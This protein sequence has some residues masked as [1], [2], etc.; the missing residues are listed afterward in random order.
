MMTKKHFR[1]LALAIAG[2][3]LSLEDKRKVAV[4][5]GTVCRAQNPKFYWETWH[6]YCGTAK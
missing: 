1:E 4:A 2:L 5:I 3:E 6:E